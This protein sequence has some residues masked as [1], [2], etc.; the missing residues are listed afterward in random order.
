MTN[1]YPRYT[2]ESQISFHPTE[3]S[4]KEKTDRSHKKKSR[5]DKIC[6]IDLKAPLEKQRGKV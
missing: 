5:Q 3:D 6:W 2:K 1:P 4:R